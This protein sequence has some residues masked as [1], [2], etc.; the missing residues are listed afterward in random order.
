M[1]AA[2]AAAVLAVAVG[3]CRLLWQQKAEAPGQQQA[4]GQT[5][6]SAMGKNVN[7]HN[8]YMERGAC[9]STCRLH[10]QR[11]RPYCEELAGQPASPVA[12]LGMQHPNM[13][14]MLCVTM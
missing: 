6:I 11:T 5:A 8:H 10:P 7:Q 13:H 1:Y 2:V 9:V 3:S 14:S 12:F 4:H